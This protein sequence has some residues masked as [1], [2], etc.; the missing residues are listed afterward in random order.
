[1]DSEV[2]VALAPLI[3]SCGGPCAPEP[4]Y[5]LRFAR[6]PIQLEVARAEDHRQRVKQDGTA[7]PHDGNREG[8]QEDHFV[9]NERDVYGIHGRVVALAR[10][11]PERTIRRVHAAGDAGALEAPVQSVQG[12]AV[13]AVEDYGP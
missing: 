13:G 1:M 9:I 12:D 7:L 8:Y 10:L 11:G 6:G 4:Q 3:T 5:A 2:A